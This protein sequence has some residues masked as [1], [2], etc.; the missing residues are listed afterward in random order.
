MRHHTRCTALTCGYVG[1]MRPLNP[2][3]GRYL[4]QML[5]E[6]RTNGPGQRAERARSAEGFEGE[7]QGRLKQGGGSGWFSRRASPTSGG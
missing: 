4:A 3:L 5:G 2:D 6:R 7:E 1:T